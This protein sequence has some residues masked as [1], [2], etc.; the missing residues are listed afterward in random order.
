MTLIAAAASIAL[1]AGDP[2]TARI[3]DASAAAQA[4]RGPLDGPW[5][6]RDGAGRVV[7]VFEITDPPGSTGPARGAWRD[8]SDRIGGAGFAPMPRRRLRITFDGGATLE[9]T[10]RRPGVWRGAAPTLGAVTLTRG[11]ASR[12]PPV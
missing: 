5:T 9:L 6:L 12:G 11:L 8:L 7:Y 1:I 3:A 4:L 2:L 10:E